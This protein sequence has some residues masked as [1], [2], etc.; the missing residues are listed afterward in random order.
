MVTVMIPVGNV[1]EQYVD[2][3]VQSIRDN[4]VGSLEILIERDTEKEGHRVLTNRMAKAARG[5]YLLRIDA[6]STMSPGWDARMKASCGPTTLLTPVID[7]L[8]EE[9]WTGKGRDMAMVVL[10][11]TMQNTYP[12]FAE[13]ITDRPDEIETMSILGC[14]YMMQKEYYWHHEGCEEALGTWGAGGLEWVFKVWLTGGRVIA[15]TDTV[16]CHLFRA[17][18]KLPYG[19]DLVRLNQTFMELGNRWRDGLGRGQTRPLAWLSQKFEKYLN[20]KV[21]WAGKNN[22]YVFPLEARAKLQSRP[23]PDS[24]S[25]NK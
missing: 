1:D 2:R 12:I 4:A 13:S 21:Q 11:P 15:R 16:C 19:I 8:D 9:T 22:S 18:G 3:T 10:T 14:T 23:T 25:G 17:D 20:N 7:A 24:G 6:H 5:K